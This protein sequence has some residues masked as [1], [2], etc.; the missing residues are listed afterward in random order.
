MHDH[1]ALLDPSDPLGVAVVLLGTLGTV[2]AFVLA[3]RM[4]VWPG[5][6]DPNHPKHAIL[7]E[8]R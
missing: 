5:E 6:T 8:D 7:R 2:F 4:T 3:F 1:H